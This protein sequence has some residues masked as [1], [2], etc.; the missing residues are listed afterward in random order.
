MTESGW[1][2][3]RYDRNEQP[4][5]WCGLLITGNVWSYDSSNAVRFSRE[6]DADTVARNLPSPSG[7]AHEHVW[8]DLEL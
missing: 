8:I 1:L 6:I 5:Y 2:I 7:T 4:M 3:E